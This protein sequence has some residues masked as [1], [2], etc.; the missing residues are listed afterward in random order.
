M[1]V[2]ALENDLNKIFNLASEE[3]EIDQHEA[4]VVE[5]LKPYLK[6]RPKHGR[7]WLMYGESLKLL[8]RIDE[9]KEAM[10]QSLQLAPKE[11]KPAIYGR[12]GF[13]YSKHVSM[14]EA[15]KWFKMGT[16]DEYCTYGWV[17]LLRGVN[18]LSGCQ[19]NSALNCFKN[20]LRFED[21]DKSEIYLN[22]GI[23][24]RSMGK[25]DSA[26]SN[27]YEALKLAPDYQEAKECIEGLDKIKETIEK[28]KRIKG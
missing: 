25:Y 20:S 21:I 12:I 10:Q 26:V 13:L 22:I 19:Y 4:H 3:A 8:S 16:D 28:A 5:L 9:A 2:D 27:F 24:Y 6:L 14:L 15:E 18:L 11:K 7:A 17:W 1:N 23:T